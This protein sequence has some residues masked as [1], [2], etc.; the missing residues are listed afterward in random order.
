[1]SQVIDSLPIAPKSLV[2]FC[3]ISDVLINLLSSLGFVYVGVLGSAFDPAVSVSALS[4]G[5]PFVVLCFSLCAF[6]GF[7]SYLFSLRFSF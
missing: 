6:L 1:M 5:F 3:N 7:L 4:L 2:W